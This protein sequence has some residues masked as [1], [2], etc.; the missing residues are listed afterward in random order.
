MNLEKFK[1]EELSIEH[2]D[3]CPAFFDMTSIG[4][5]S[6][7]YGTSLPSYDVAI[8]Y[9]SQGEIDYITIIK[10][11]QEV[12]RKIVEE[13]IR[14]K[15]IILSL[16]SE[17]MKNYGMMMENYYKEF[18]KDFNGLGDAEL[19][20]KSDKLFDFYVNKVSMPG[21][22]DGF[23][24]YA[25]KRFAFLVEEFCKKNNISDHIKMAATLTASVEPSFLNEEEDNLVKIIDAV[26]ERYPK[27]E[28][29]GV[30]RSES[31]REVGD[32]IKK[33]LLKYS[34]IKS[35]YFGY[36]EY[37]YA[38]AISEIESL[39]TK[40]K[41]MLDD[42]F[43]AHKKEKNDLINEYNFSEEILAI[44]ELTELLIKWQ[45]YRKIYTL[46]YVSLREKLLREIARRRNI[47]FE[48]LRYSLTNESIKILNGEYDLKELESRK[49]G[50]VS[51]YE[52]GKLVEI[53]SGEDAINFRR[54]L[55]RE[56]EK[57]ISEIK[58]IVA[59]IGKVSGIAKIVLSVKNLDKVN[60]G[61]ILVAPMTRPEHISAMK[62]AAAIVTDDGG[63]TCH[64]AIVARE[65]KKPCI[66]GTKIATKV[67]KDG[68]EVEV[69][70]NAG[71]VR[72]IK[73][74]ESKNIK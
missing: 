33:H 42:I 66:I 47:D 17:W 61:D 12:G 60:E 16:N 6:R 49:K 5:T 2:A 39:I 23:M 59:S 69:D 72:I 10:N 7:L 13:Y 15:N 29:V 18:Q 25:D 62:K 63:I 22:I 38:D 34:W 30:L 68:D 28:I 55:F 21:L 37:S 35:N 45:D 50:C 9:F 70:A 1:N 8:S 64:A 67:L 58:G 46:T 52:N 14:D 56:V 26:R 71:I 73:K 27:D 3:G 31:D 48:L 43:S 40:D 20:E 54:E 41:K 4:F 74:A 57:D 24:F 32:L 36:K 44:V 53:F 11:Q 65:L 19:I 51:V